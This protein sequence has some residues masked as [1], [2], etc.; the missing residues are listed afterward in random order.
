MYRYGLI[1]EGVFPDS[2]SFDD[3]RHTFMLGIEYVLKE[4]DA[5]KWI[6]KLAA[7]IGTMQ[8]FDGEDT[9][10]FLFNLRFEIDF[11]LG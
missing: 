5:A 3:P 1:S 4:P 9:R 7:S 10:L 6:P 11:P 8:S 2:D